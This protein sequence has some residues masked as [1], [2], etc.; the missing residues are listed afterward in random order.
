MKGFMLQKHK[1]FLVPFRVEDEEFFKELKNNQTSVWNLV[2]KGGTKQ[3]SFQQLK[4]FMG[5]IRVLTTNTDDPKC[6]TPDRAKLYIKHCLNY[7]DADSTIV[8]PNGSVILKYRSFNYG[9]LGHMEACDILNK[10]LALIADILGITV[11]ELVLAVQEKRYE[12]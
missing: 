8:T 4:T 2:S 12:L 5:A 10:G 11:E 3:R 7:I 1:G 9:D 6:S